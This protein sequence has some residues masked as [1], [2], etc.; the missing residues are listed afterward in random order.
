[1]SATAPRSPLS[2]IELVKA[3]LAAP[4]TATAVAGALYADAMPRPAA[5]DVRQVYGVLDFADARRSLVTPAL[6]A[7]VTSDEA[8]PNLGGDLDEGVVQ[9]EDVIVSVIAIVS[10]KNDLGGRKG[11]TEDRLTPLIRETRTALVGWSPDGEFPGRDI[12]RHDATTLR[13]LGI[14]PEAGQD[15]E[16]DGRWRPLVRARG[17]LVG[18]E[19]GRAWWQ[20]DYRTHRLVAG[21]PLDLPEG[22]VPSTL[23]VSVDG[24]PPELLNELS[25][26]DWVLPAGRIQHALMLC[27]ASP[28]T[29]FGTN[30]VIYRHPDNRG[31]SAQGAFRAGSDVIDFPVE[32]DSRV[33]ELQYPLFRGE[34][35]I[36]DRPDADSLRA[37]MESLTDVQ[38]HVQTIDGSLALGPSDRQVPFGPNDG[39]F[40]FFDGA[41]S[42]I[43]TNLEDGDLFILAITSAATEEAA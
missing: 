16:P 22:T 8:G 14:L 11:V 37:G 6:A 36:S 12:A 18:V 9:R 39:I 20:D 15:P 29:I 31:G 33:T 21:V 13:I 24:A 1:M 25:L 35:I 26:T 30:V 4:E 41:P 43:L 17:R 7:I 27:S 42:P 38:L 5:L 34:V 2:L 19:D 40:G 28:L 10:A 32:G 23:C 3:R